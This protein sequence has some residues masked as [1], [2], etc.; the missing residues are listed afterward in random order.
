MEPEVKL[1]LT[2]RFYAGGLMMLDEG[3]LVGVSKSTACNIIRY[4]SHEIAKLASEF[5]KMPTGD[6]IQRNRELFYKR[7]RFPRAI[8]SLDSTYIRILSPGTVLVE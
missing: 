8:S 6:A 4:V 5:I 1:L 2:L 3:E 7:A